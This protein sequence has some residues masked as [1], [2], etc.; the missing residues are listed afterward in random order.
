MTDLLSPDEV[1][2]RL[3]HYLTLWEENHKLRNALADFSA[4]G[5][6]VLRVFDDSKSGGCLA[7]GLALEIMSANHLL[8]SSK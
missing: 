7:Q 2:N 1:Q 4:A 5:A 6:E 3:V 8:E